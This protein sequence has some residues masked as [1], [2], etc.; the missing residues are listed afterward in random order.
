MRGRRAG[1]AVVVVVGAG[2]FGSSVQ[3]LTRLDSRLA[4]DDRQ[5]DAVKQERRAAEK[6]D[7]PW[8]EDR[9]S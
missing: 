4:A 6:P 2:L 1:I 5:R 8:R 7:C 9:R 3:G